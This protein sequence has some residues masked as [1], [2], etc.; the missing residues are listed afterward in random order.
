MFGK[1]GFK[2]RQYGMKIKRGEMLNC[3]VALKAQKNSAQGWSNATTLG[4]AP[5]I[6][7]P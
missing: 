2:L 5:K 3:A 4:N 7:P 1:T 6:F